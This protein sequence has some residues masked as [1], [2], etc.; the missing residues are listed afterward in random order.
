MQSK[1]SNHHHHARCYLWFTTKLLLLFSLST[2]SYGK[3]YK[4]VDEKGKVHFGDK[5]LSN[6][7][8]EEVTLKAKATKWKK[9]EIEITDVDNIL[10][11][12]E[13]QRIARD[14]NAV[15]HFFDNKLYFDFYRTVPVKIHLFEKQKSYQHYLLSKGVKNKKGTRGIYIGKSNEIVLPLNQEIRWRTFWTI[16]HETTHAIIDSATPFVPAWLNEGLAENME[17]LGFSDGSLIIY[18]HEENWNSTN[19]ANRTGKRLDVKQLLSTSST[20]FYAS[21]KHRNNSYQAYAG[22]LVRMFLSTKPGMSLVRRMIHEYKRGSRLYGANILEEHYLGGLST[23]QYD[24]N[25]WVTR[26]KSKRIK[27]N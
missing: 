2:L 19:K 17:S 14:V 27:L 26:T 1:Y 25:T 8:Q 11:K 21:M 15:Y 18:P 10:T 3:I 5:S 4:W 6:I 9:Y 12:K 24:W 7:N 23:L 13:R 22:E 20:N 16:K